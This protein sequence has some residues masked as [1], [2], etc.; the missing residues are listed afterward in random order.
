MD[1]CQQSPTFITKNNLNISAVN[2]LFTLASKLDSYIY[3]YSYVNH[4]NFLPVEN[5]FCIEFVI[6]G[7]LF[8]DTFI[9][10]D[11]DLACFVANNV[12]LDFNGWGE[13]LE[14]RWWNCFASQ[15]FIF[16]FSSFTSNIKPAIFHWMTKS[17]KEN[18]PHKT[19]SNQSKKS[20]P[21]RLAS[22]VPDNQLDMSQHS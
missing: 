14:I 15:F 4:S 20:I 17:K 7:A 1:S 19:K 6:T 12:F 13:W 5:N 21:Y 10:N 2:V 18:Y 8:H 3:G 9:I 22:E 11:D 16:Y